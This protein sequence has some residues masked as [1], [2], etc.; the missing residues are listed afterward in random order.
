MV[1]AMIIDLPW[2]GTAAAIILVLALFTWLSYRA[3]SGAPQRRGILTVG[4]GVAYAWAGVVSAIVVAY[5]T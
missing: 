2:Y 4:L 5:V 3:F 1:R